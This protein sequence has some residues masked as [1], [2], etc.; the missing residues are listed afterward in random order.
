MYIRIYIIYY[1]MYILHVYNTCN[2]TTC[3]RTFFNL[4]FTQLVEEEKGPRILKLA[5]SSRRIV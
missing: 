5:M 3:N 1:T 2:R 4:K